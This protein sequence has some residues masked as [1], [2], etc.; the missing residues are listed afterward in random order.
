M[1]LALKQQNSLD[2]APL[3]TNLL[4]ILS[5]ELLSRHI[6]YSFAAVYG[7]ELLHS[8]NNYSTLVTW[9][10]LLLMQS[11]KLWKACK[12]ILVT[13]TCQIRSLVTK[14]DFIFIE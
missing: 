11:C 13:S 9:Q 7:A 12:V 14:M 6:S 1:I 8:S 10:I 3:N 2:T 5:F 4:E